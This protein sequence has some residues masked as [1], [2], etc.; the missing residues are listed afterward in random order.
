M[1][2]HQGEES[3]NAPAKGFFSRR[4]VLAAAGGA[5][6]GF[7]AGWLA[8]AI[9][10]GAAADEAVPRNAQEALDR[11]KAGN[12]RF[13]TGRMVRH[14]QGRAWRHALTSEQH[15]FASVLGCSDSRV[16]VELVLDQGF[17]DLFIVRVAGNVV[18]SDILGSLA[19][20][21]AHVH[22]PL[23]VVLG[24]EGCGAVTAALQGPARHGEPQRLEELLHL[25]EPGLRGLDPGLQGPARLSA[26]VAANV[27]WSLRQFA[28]L[29][30]GRRLSADHAI[31][32]VGGIYDLESGRVR[33]LDADA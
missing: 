3:P 1:S 28:E 32:L 23:V 20:A 4:Q 13:R 9:T 22:T 25:I 30:A 15:P 33:F 2:K 24:H 26:A 8:H 14:H 11:L 19:Y 21:L 31:L 5:A 17:G 7:A 6:V 18:A 27:R 16:P 10:R 12:E 29:P